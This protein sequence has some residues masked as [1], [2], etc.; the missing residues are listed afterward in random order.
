[1]KTGDV[2]SADIVRATLLVGG[3]LLAFWMMH[4]TVL[5]LLAV[6]LAVVFGVALS[7]GVDRLVT[8]RIPRALGASLIMIVFFGCVTG[9]G[10]WLAP[11]IRTQSVELKQ[12][13]P[14]ALERVQGWI[15]KKQSGLENLIVDQQAS[16]DSTAVVAPH[17]GRTGGLRDRLTRETGGA[18]RFIFP[19]LHDTAVVVGGLLFIIFLTIYFGIEPETYRRGVV[20]IFPVAR[21][22]Q[23][24][25]VLDRIATVLRKWL[26]TQLIIMAVMGAVSTAALFLLHVKA[27]V[28]LGVL[29]GVVSFIPTIGGIVAAV[30]AIAMG[31]LDSPEKALIVGIVYVL[32]HFAGSHVLVPV[33]MKGGIDL[34]PALTLIAQAMLTALFGF[35]GLM[36]AVPLLATVLVIVRSTYAEPMSAQS[37]S[38]VSDR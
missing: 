24:T 36:V 2:R 38:D 15:D 12:K 1:M 29:A 13:L 22:P 8:W 23:V 3:A 26:V 27:A 25:I 28:A 21:R 30:P 20:A 16:V 32:I 6:F 17:V 37:G 33:L 5:I 9:L 7:A 10:L 31:F 14:I 19:V 34:P 11:T 18:S 4:N 35:L